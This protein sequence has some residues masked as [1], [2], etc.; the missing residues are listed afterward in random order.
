[1]PVNGPYPKSSTNGTNT[2]ISNLSP[3]LGNDDD[4]KRGRREKRKKRG[5][6][7]EGKRRKRRRTY[8]SSSTQIHQSKRVQQLG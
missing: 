8:V 5:E 2:L 6:E 7:K 4:R 3:R 1:M